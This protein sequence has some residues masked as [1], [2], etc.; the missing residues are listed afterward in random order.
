MVIGIF[1]C[2]SAAT[3]QAG[4]ATADA[5]G[6]VAIP[7]ANDADILVMG[8]RMAGSAIGE[9]EP[10]AVLN[11]DAIHALGAVS[12]KELIERLK[13]LTTSATGG[14][15]VLL[16]NGRR[17][18]S[19]QEL[20]TI[21]PEAIERTEVL[22]EAEAARFG[23][24]PTV[25]ILNFITKKQFR[26]VTV[27]LLPGTATEGGGETNYAEMTATR[28]DGPR[29]ASLSVSHL[30]INPVEQTQR[31]ILPDPA[32]LYAVQGNVTGINGASLDPRLDALA[33]AAVPVAAV[34]TDPAARGALAGY[35]ATANR[36]AVTDLGPWRWLQP[37]S[38]RVT[39][40]ATIGSPIGRSLDGSL[41]LSMEAQHS[42]G[43]NGLAPVLLT[44]PGDNPALPFGDDVLL[45]RYLPDTVLRQRNTSLNLHAGG[46]L[47][48]G[49]GRWTWNTTT[50]YDRV[51]GVAVS[52]QG[53]AVD[54]L[55][56]AVVAGGNPLAPIDPAQAV[57]I[58]NRSRTV[59]GTVVSKVVATGPTLR[60]PAG[61]AQVTLTAD[62]ARSSSSGFQSAIADT[63]VDLTRT[64]RG[65]SINA[66]LPIARPDGQ[67]LTRL[68][69]LSANGMIGLSDVSDFG[70]LLNL[71]YGMNW[72]PMRPVQFNASVNET[73]AAPAI[74]LLTDPTLA[75]PNIPFFDFATGNSVLVTTVVGGNA[76]LA[77]ER[78]RVTTLGVAVTPLKG[79]DLRFGLDYL[80]TRIRNQAVMLGA[81]TP[82][83]QRA[84]PDRFVRDAGGVL[85]QVDLRSVNIDRERER[86]LRLT[87]SL[88]L[89]IGPTPPP[90]PAPPAG[91]SATLPTPPPAPPKPRPSIFASV[92]TS[93]RLDNVVTLRPGLAPLDLL[94][95]E[96]L[97]GTGGRPRWEVEANIG[98]NMG[99]FNLG[100]FSR[101]QGPT[102]IRSD[103][104]ASDLRFS[105]R[106]WIVLYSQ[107]DIEKLVA[108]PWTK[109][110]SM[111]LTVENLLNDRI[112][113]TD[114][115]GAVPNRFQPAFI[116]PVGRSIRVGVRKLF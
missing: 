85:T 86:K 104:A 38:D 35:L 89:Q 5:G 18:S 99:P 47:Q 29:R 106:T 60:L 10:V 103:L 20:Q 13:P 9:I 67:F 58:A 4:T 78:R 28:I 96:T 80:D 8:K 62:Y 42:V 16:L 81:A 71:N 74:S 22:P 111:Q 44:V 17:I 27:Q 33:G 84:F 77:P 6:Q 70:R 72:A 68:G 59:T 61:P 88:Y 56:D 108:R 49:L 105:A 46:T 31:R 79:K 14:E 43:H 12:M 63:R 73:Q 30:R 95:G 90:P 82:A 39:V 36:P 1:A 2:L 11:P 101:L 41:N 53:I 55:Q 98:G 37:R 100:T 3:M 51:R 113:V 23:F 48:G 112:D 92:T 114:R 75:A 45:Y 24:A 91:L 97:N 116:D 115:T 25:R 34:P 15:P 83:V 66:T 64:T 57:L 26:A 76:A 93:M 94:D 52:D 102:R 110:L 40:D 7:T 21:P 69:Q 87:T 107:I 50:N 65:G 19:Y 109:R 54:P 32:V